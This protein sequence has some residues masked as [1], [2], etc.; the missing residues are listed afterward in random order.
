M[1]GGGWFFMKWL[2]LNL[3]YIKVCVICKDEFVCLY[4]YFEIDYVSVVVFVKVV[5]W[6]L[7]WNGYKCFE[8]KLMV[9]RY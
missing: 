1:G 4:Y 7:G 6:Y 5:G 3:G 9:S 8:K 2:C